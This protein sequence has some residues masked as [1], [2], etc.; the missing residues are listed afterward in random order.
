RPDEEAV[1]AVAYDVGDAPDRR[2]DDRPPGGQRLDRDDRRALVRGRHHERVE[3]AVVRRHVALIAGEDRAANDAEVVRALLDLLAVGAVA[4]Q[5]QRRVYAARAEAPER[6]EQ[7]ADALDR[8]HAADP[9][10]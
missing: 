10:D 3:E 1:D 8:R 4:D 9:P 7:V 5:A 2:G 6:L